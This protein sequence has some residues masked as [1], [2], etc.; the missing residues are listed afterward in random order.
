M[1]ASVVLK[2]QMVTILSPGNI[3]T[4]FSTVYHLKARVRDYASKQFR[5]FI[6]LTSIVWTSIHGIQY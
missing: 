5:L 2:T 6:S 4:L 3:L 1:A